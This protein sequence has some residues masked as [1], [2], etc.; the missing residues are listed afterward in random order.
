MKFLL[1][2]HRNGYSNLNNRLAIDFHRTLIAQP[3]AFE[4]AI[5]RNLSRLQLYLLKIISQAIGMHIF[6][7][8]VN[9]ALKKFLHRFQSFLIQGAGA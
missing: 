5:G 7:Q 1:L 6:V 8:A 2:L 9:F 3:P 4:D